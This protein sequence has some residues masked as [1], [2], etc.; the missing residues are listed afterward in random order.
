MAGSVW[1]IC[2]SCRVACPA[3][4]ADW[5]EQA[6]SAT[7]AELDRLVA[8]VARSLDGD[9]PRAAFERRPRLPG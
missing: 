7:G 2:T 5:V 8:A 3:D 9:D 6:R 1:E 4:E